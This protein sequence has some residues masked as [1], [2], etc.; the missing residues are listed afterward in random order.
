MSGIL[1][2]S[3]GII[4]SGDIVSS[5]L[6]LYLTAYAYTSGSTWIDQSG[7]GNNG[8]L[9]NSPAYTTISGVKTFTFNG[10][11][12]QVSFTYQ[13][14]IQ[15]SSTAFTWCAWIRAN[16]NFDGDL[17]MGYRGG[18]GPPPFAKMTTQKM[19]FYPAEVFSPPPTATWIML[20]GIYNG[21]GTSGG[22]NLQWYHNNASVGLRD[23]DD[24]ILNGSA[25][26]FNVGG[27]AVANEWFQGYI[28]AVAVYN[29]AL[30][31]TE[32]TQNYN[33]TKSRYGF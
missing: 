8:T 21:A 15:T 3:S 1:T 11:S 19:E 2:A 4:S 10:T 25:M 22:T 23:A 14:P 7:N 29:R 26:P 5:G 18:V 30:S 9:V 31:S 17:I 20:T 6:S 27:D 28:S 33:A 16:R 32:V 12:N 24:P 13:L